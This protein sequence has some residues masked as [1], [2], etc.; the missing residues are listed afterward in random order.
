MTWRLAVVLAVASVNLHADQRP[1]QSNPVPEQLTV[2]APQPLRITIPLWIEPPPK[3]IGVLTIV[4]PDRRGEVI[5]MSLPVGDL[6]MRAARAIGQ[7]RQHRAEQ[8]ARREVAQ[9]I[10]DLQAAQREEPR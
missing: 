3:R 10:K 5:Q 7:T 6:T 2:A 8:Q 1:T 9:A 4:P